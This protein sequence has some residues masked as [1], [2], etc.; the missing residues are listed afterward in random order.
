MPKNITATNIHKLREGEI[1][2]LKKDFVMN[3]GGLDEYTILRGS[4][5]SIRMIPGSGS[6]QLRWE[7]VKTKP[8]KRIL[9]GHAHTMPSKYM[10]EYFVTCAHLQDTLDN[11]IDKPKPTRLELLVL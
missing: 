4:R 7:E 10:I 5:A 3:K 6:Y 11:P 2:L 9:T 8:A 1:L